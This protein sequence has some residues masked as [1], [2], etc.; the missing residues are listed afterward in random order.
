MKTVFILCAVA[1]AVYARP[2]EHYTERYDVIDLHEVLT[3]RRLLVPYVKCLL[4]QGKC[5]PEGKELKCK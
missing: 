1:V 4:D 3:N 2:E 5:S